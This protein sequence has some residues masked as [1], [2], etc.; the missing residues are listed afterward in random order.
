MKKM[1]K[2]AVAFL[3]P[4]ELQSTCTSLIQYI[5]HFLFL[6]N[7]KKRFDIKKL[8]KVCVQKCKKVVKNTICIANMYLLP[9]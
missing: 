8:Q 3:P 4:A 1:A 9:I 2:T 5:L 6:R 7:Y